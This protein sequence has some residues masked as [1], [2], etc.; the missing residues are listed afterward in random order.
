[1]RVARFDFFEARGANEDPVAVLV[2]ANAVEN[3]VGL[4]ALRTR[5]DAD[6]FDFGHR[7]SPAAIS[8]GNDVAR[9]RRWFR[10]TWLRVW[11]C[12]PAFAF[13]TS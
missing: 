8:L 4:G 7:A 11:S 1:M 2:D 10:Q 13:A 12:D 5:L 6:T 3:V 9:R